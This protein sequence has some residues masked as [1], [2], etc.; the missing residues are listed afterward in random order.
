MES[1]G[2][3]A[4]LARQAALCFLQRTRAHACTERCENTFGK[5]QGK[6]GSI[7]R[8]GQNAALILLLLDRGHEGDISTK[9]KM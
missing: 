6:K 2:V 8:K 1:T 3:E 7:V 4:A 5:Y 9:R